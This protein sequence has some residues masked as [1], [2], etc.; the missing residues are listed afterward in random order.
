[1]LAA[2]AL[3]GVGVGGVGRQ[4]AGAAPHETPARKITRLRA[5]AARVQAA[6]DRMNARV[7][8]LV[9]DYNEV[10]EALA[11]TRVEQ[12][13][14]REQ[15]LEARRRLRVARRQL[16]KRLW[17]IYTGGAP[18]TLGQLLGADSIH[19]ALVTTKYQEEVV[20]ADR[21]AVDRVERLRRQV[22]ALAAKLADQAERQQRLQARL[23]AK[24]RQIEARLSAQR[25]YHQR[26]TRQV[27]RVVAEERRRQEA[28]RRRAL[29]RRLA[30]ARAARAA[31]RAGA[32]SGAAG[33]AVAFAR[34]QLGKPYVWGAAGPSA[35]DCSG[36]V[37]AAYRRAG[38]W[39]PRV[40]R[41]Q[42]NAGPHVGLGGLAP[43]D[44]VFFAYNV[45][46][47]STIHHVGM[48]VGGGAMVEAPYSGAR[49]RIA[50]IGRRDYI[51]A[52]RPTG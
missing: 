36:L 50:S 19:Q 32:P 12:A 17:T 21:A 26:L 9:E 24:R 16:G 43:G 42:W 46:S 30:A 38:V 51:G 2:V 3:G 33:R 28:L 44:L 34:S 31:T 14:T 6:I 10:R 40:S 37:M 29:L 27:R 8:R 4:V 35:Y 48:Y 13:R 20:G 25:R 52:V 7:E 23:A 22:E 5:K 1:V 49:V 47:P 45:G 15:V 39:L 41:E 11:R 18:S